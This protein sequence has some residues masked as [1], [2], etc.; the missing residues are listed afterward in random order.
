VKIFKKLL[1]SSTVLFLSTPA[2]AGLAND[3]ED[4]FSN[5]SNKSNKGFLVAQNKESSSDTLK[6]TVTGT[7]T[8]RPLDTFPG[9][10]NVL[11]QDDLNNRKGNTIRAL[12]D[13]VPGV[14]TKAT[15]RSGVKG[16][17]DA[18][19]V[20]IRG[21]DFNRVLFLVD[22]IRLPEPYKYSDYY[23]FS[24]GSYVDFNT[25]TSVEILKGPA[26]ALYGADALAGL[27]SYRSL[28]ASDL[29]EDG[30]NQ[31]FEIPFNYYSSNDGTDASI[32]Y[33]TRLGDK[34][35][36]A[37][38]YTREDS[39]ALNVKADDKFKDDE[40]NFGNNIF[41]NLTTK[42]GDFSE[43]N[44]TYE[45]VSRESNS[46]SSDANLTAMNSYYSTYKKLES[47]TTTDRNRYSISYNY[48]NPNNEKLINSVNIK[49]YKQDSYSEDNFD[50]TTT[51]RGRDTLKEHRYY[52]ENYM[53]GADLQ[54]QSKLNDHQLTYGIDYSIVDT[55]RLRTT[56]TIGGSTVKEKDTPDTE[57]KRTGIYLQDEISYGKFDFIAGLRYDNYNLDAKT[58]SVYTTEAWAVDLDESNISPKIAATYR[59]N[60]KLSAYSQY[61]KGFRAPA[62]YEVNGDYSNPA[63]GYT[64]KSN[65]DLEPETSDSYEIG[66]SGRYKQFDFNLAGFYNKYEDFIEQFKNTGRNAAGLT[67]YQSV[68]VSEAE[69]S[70]VELEAEYYLKPERYGISLFTKLAYAEGN[71]ETDDEPLTSIN[72]FEAKIG[73][74]Y[75]SED[76]RWNTSLTNTFVGEPRVADGTT[77]FVPDSYS[78]TD[79]TISFKPRDRY[80]LSAGIYNI[81]DEEYY[82]YQDVKGKSKTLSNLTRF[83]QPSRNIQVGF[84]IKF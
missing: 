53:S 12:T 52:L 2:L 50:R 73:F 21:L 34:N 67:L 40:T 16:P 30:Q 43:I 41:L 72:P 69:I 74:K 26:S 19:N 57:I 65:S 45:N 1:I 61:S 28:K 6:I 54:L 79:A 13:D 59:F 14:T 9:S 22:G 48:K 37:L 23:N 7:R 27:I 56:R 15:Q 4:Q 11:D 29:L 83:T 60:D 33:A 35:S 64:V 51:A 39:G 63:R 76:D 3:F 8:P 80:E 5:R 25:L 10:I 68:N 32:K 77:S 55:E 66:L 42:I 82:N 20:N 71:N 44:T 81:F 78:T 62:Y 49:L 84:K 38:V 58:D 17:T 24:Q 75:S 46:I 18:G 31:A 70:G 36:L 47:D